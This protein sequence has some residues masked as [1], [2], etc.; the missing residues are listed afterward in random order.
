MFVSGGSL[1]LKTPVS[2]T[3]SSWFSG[4]PPMSNGW[5]SA[6]G[7]IYKHHLWV[8]TVVSKL[9]KATARLPLP[10]YERDELNRPRVP[11]HPLQALLS[12]PNPSLSAFDLWIWTS[13]TYDIYGEAFWLKQRENGR[14]MSLWPLHPAHMSYDYDNGAWR[15]ENGSKVIPRIDSRDLVHFRSY[16]PDSMTNGLSPL[17]PLR[18]TLENEYYAR[19][20]TSSF[21]QRGARPGLA[22]THQ[23]T[24]S[25][26]AADRLKAQFDRI[27]AGAGNTG[28]TVVLEEGMKAERLTL[29]AEEAQYI[30]SRKLNREEVCGAYDVPPP[31]VHILD[32]A[33]FSNITEQMRSMYRDTMAPRLRHFES[34]IELD[35]RQAEFGGDDVYA[36][37]LMD[38]VL[39]GDFEA[40]AAAY[41][42]AD[43]MTIAEKRRSENLPWIE[44]TDRLFLNA[45]VQPMAAPTLDDAPTGP[46]FQQVGLPALIAAGVITEDDARDLLGLDGPAPGVPD[47]LPA[48]SARTVNGRL[49]WQKFLTDIDVPTLV[50]GLN[51]STG[52]VLR[53]L[54]AEAV[55]DGD[56]ASLR[57]RIRSL[58]KE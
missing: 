9:A 33:T 23:A 4:M 26:P 49:A 35:L 53:A 7:A 22:L 16:N 57:E 48:A 19:L 2:L 18:S 29:S 47:V 30:D 15:F 8:Y 43:Y 5:F 56:V 27:A 21:W 37:F 58:V 44:G 41:R 46:Q 20:A 3:S 1:V 50:A 13:S 6:Y 42:S 54:E 52:V 14:V 24:L 25:Q 40:R 31:V 32:R 10:V 39:R 28:T 55:A 36:E 34:V 51:G 45:A 17:E 12:R 11:N 38:E